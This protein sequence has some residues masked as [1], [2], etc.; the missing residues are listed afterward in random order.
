MASVESNG[1][2][3]DTNMLGGAHYLKYDWKVHAEFMTSCDPKLLGHPAIFGQKY[4]MI[5]TNGIGQ[6]PC[7]FEHYLVSV[8]MH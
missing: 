4:L 8:K 6:T 2:G 3:R 5:V 7:S 1:Q